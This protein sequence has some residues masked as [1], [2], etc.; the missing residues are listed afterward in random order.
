MPEP[1]GLPV[2]FEGDL[3]DADRR[4]L[5]FG[6]MGLDG[7]TLVTA[8]YHGWT[9]GVTGT[10]DALTEAQAAAY[11]LAGRVVIPNL[12]YRNDIGARLISGDFAAVERLGLLD[13]V[14]PEARDR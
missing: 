1:I 3:T 2:L 4:N 11:R 10:G 14:A 6:E 7:D 5:H 9:L 12:R 13:P 8:G